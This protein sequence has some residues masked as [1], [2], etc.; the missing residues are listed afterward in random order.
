[1]DCNEEQGNWH[2][3]KTES[4]CDKEIPETYHAGFGGHGM[5]YGVL[6]RDLILSRFL[7]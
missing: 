2:V 3:I 4:E 5:K 7:F 6:D 1:M